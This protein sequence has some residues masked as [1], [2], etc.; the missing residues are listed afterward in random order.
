MNIFN[1]NFFEDIRIVREEV[2]CDEA[3]ERL[4]SG[5]ELSRVTIFW[6]RSWDILCSRAYNRDT[7]TNL[8]SKEGWQGMVTPAIYIA[9]RELPDEEWAALWEYD[10]LTQPQ[11]HEHSK[12]YKHIRNTARYEIETDLLDGVTLDRDLR[13]DKREC[14]PNVEYGDGKILPLEPIAPNNIEE[15]A[16][17]NVFA[18]QIMA[19]LTEEDIEIL[20]ADH[21]DGPGLAEKY[22][23]S[24]EAIRVRRHRL[25]KNLQEKYSV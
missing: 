18:H 6:G 24:E 9:I 1:E 4:A 16:L 19:K 12:L 22:N 11:H 3:L 10:M 17:N 25:I 2:D 13:I 23:M 8:M 21:G 14:D 20:T 7:T 15:E 5:K